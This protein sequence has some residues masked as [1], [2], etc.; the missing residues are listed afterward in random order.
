MLPPVTAAEPDQ[1]P[2]ASR[3]FAWQAI[4]AHVW[5][6]SGLLLDGWYHIH[7]PQIET[8]F[9]PWHGVLYA[10]VGVAV[11]LVAHQ[12]A[13]GR[14]RGLTRRAA[15]PAGYGLT[16]LGGVLFATGAL[17]DMAWHE[18]LGI[19]V[20]VEALL[21]PTHLTLAVA[22]VL[23]F[24][25]PLRAAVRTVPRDAPAAD[26]LPAVVSAGL[27]VALIGFFT[28]YVNPFTHLYPT[29][30]ASAGDVDLLHA[31]GIAAVILFSALVAGAVAVTTL[32]WRLPFGAITLLLG[33]AVVAMTVLRGTLILV[34]AAL[35]AGLIADA[36]L[37]FRPARSGDAAGIRGTAAGVPALLFAGYFLTLATTSSIVWSVH[38][39]TGAVTLAALTGVLVG[40]LVTAG[41]TPA[42]A[43]DVTGTTHQLTGSL[44]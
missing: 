35:I 1:Q 21:S 14:R 31:A 29:L 39:V 41:L 4:G 3:A 28:Q 33:I 9:T 5:I 25:G 40:W 30:E 36:W 7:S 13:L 10:G 44:K 15:V 26:V 8:F 32:R 17:A 34:P 20:G 27:L 43:P 2:V 6:L 22:G 23:V 37:Q 42:A 12:I 18:L 19:E 24:A 38:L 16:V 11:A